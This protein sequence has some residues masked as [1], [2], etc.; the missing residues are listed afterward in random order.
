MVTVLVIA[1]GAVA[2]AVQIAGSRYAPPEALSPPRPIALAAGVPD[3]FAIGSFTAELSSTGLTVT[4]TRGEV[5]WAANGG[6]FIAAFGGSEQFE[7]SQGSL[8]WTQSR[9]EVF[10][11]QSVTS[12]RASDDG[13]SGTWEIVGQLDGD[14]GTRGYVVTLSD[15]GTGGLLV[16][17][18]IGGVDAIVLRPGRD[19]GEEIHGLG[20]QF[21]PFDLPSTYW[22]I[23]T[24]EQGV[25]RGRQPMTVLTELAQ[26]AGGDLTTTYAPM[27]RY[28]TSSNRAL[29]ILTSPL[30]EAPTGTAPTGF[31]LRGK[32]SIDI[33]AWSS[34]PLDVRVTVASSPTELIT[35]RAASLDEFTNLPPEWTS[36][37]AIVAAQGGTDAVRQK[38]QTLLDA[39]ATISAVWIQDW[40]G[41][42]Q[43]S[44]GSRVRWDWVL[45]Q[46]RY[47][48]WDQLI[49]DL[50]AKAIRVLGYVNPFLIAPQSSSVPSALYSEA[51]AH[52]F[53]VMNQVGQPYLLDQGGFDAALV[54][55]T[56]PDARSW[57]RAVVERNLVGIGFSG[58]M[59]DF[60]EGLP[61]DAVLA[62]GEAK[63]W[64][65]RWPDQWAS[66]ASNLT[67]A[68]GEQVFQFSRSAGA[69]FAATGST[70]WA[71][72]Q[73]VTWD[74][75]DGMASQVR[76]MLAASVSGVTIVLGDAGGYTSLGQPI[77]AVSRDDELLARWTQLAAWTPVL[78]THET[79][80]PDS[81]AQPW[82][83]DES[84]KAFARQS[85]VF[86]ALAPYRAAAEQEAARTGMPV[87][88]PLWLASSDPS[89]AGADDEFFFGES[90][91]VAP[92]MEP[93]A[94]S[95][96]VS[97][98]EGAWIELWSGT[99]YEGGEHEVPVSSDQI[100]V[101]YRATDRAAGQLAAEVKAAG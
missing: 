98:P 90:F 17:A 19:A 73:L 55:L 95:R 85:S 28:V 3:Q 70:L 4:N 54:D 81:N 32:Q 75:E 43:T 60:G 69:R 1:A 47:P 22:P 23:L 37:G 68:D 97:L 65:D 6:A 48:Q 5:A 20:E 18:S 40:S 27:P 38:I 52:G 11:T 33:D 56:N 42:L 26:G 59:A 8:R 72:D 100:P 7:E 101:F 10:A 49:S 53:L 83:T 16:S 77:V 87:I 84:A 39:G 76:G 24:R 93:G 80:R 64:H 51:E 99:S 92:V 29:D 44:F 57:L 71:G 82:S 46:E 79:N 91:L 13:G 89:V 25:G 63:V 21:A 96:E 74:G 45:D 88:R 78:R 15:D 67:T 58:W 35:A 41:Q 12:S 9:D 14:G 94:T 2:V 62:N 30:D 50:K 66:L 31:D 36:R 86:A 34:Q 61:M